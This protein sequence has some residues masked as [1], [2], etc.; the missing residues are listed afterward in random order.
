MGNIPKKY[1]LF[2]GL[3][4]AG[5][6]FVLIWHFWPRPELQEH[7]HDSHTHD[8][9]PSAAPVTPAA[10][11]AS[12]AAVAPPPSADGVNPVFVAFLKREAALLEST[13]NDAV[14]AEQ[15]V[16]VQAEAMGPREIS[17][18]KDTALAP[19]AAANERI[20]SAYLLVSA[21][22][23]AWSAIQE[24]LLAPLSR[25]RAEPHTIEEAKAMQEK[26][27]RLMAVDGLA[28]QA[29]TNAR[30]RELLSRMASEVQDPGLRNYI[31]QKLGE[32]PPL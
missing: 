4:A 11:P 26:A 6:L 17:F 21:G 14:K 13:K 29:A 18:A 3:S 23:K 22:E 32:L 2:G 19:Q 16:E 8:P 10:A 31:L 20:L 1:W 12:P 15:R 24:L 30:A 9:S 7:A 25:A 5:L 27:L 28:E